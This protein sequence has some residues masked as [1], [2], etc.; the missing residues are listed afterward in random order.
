MKI[1]L[2]FVASAKEEKFKWRELPSSTR[3][4]VGCGA[5]PHP[6]NFEGNCRSVVNTKKKLRPVRKLPSGPDCHWNFP[7]SIQSIKKKNSVRSVH[8]PPDRTVL[9]KSRVPVIQSSKT[10]G[11]GRPASPTEG[12]RERRARRTLEVKETGPL[13]RRE[14]DGPRTPDRISWVVEQCEVK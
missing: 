7:I 10:Y 5:P 9:E 2:E 1:E 13:R 8:Y 12:P 3:N 4:A 14:M 6:V 11:R